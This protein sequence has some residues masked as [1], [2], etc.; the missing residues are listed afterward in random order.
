VIFVDLR[1]R[2]GLVQIVFNPSA[3]IFE[4][5]GELRHEIRGA[6]TG[7]CARTSR[8]NGQCQSGIGRRRDR[9][10]ELELL[11]RSDPLPFQLDENVNEKCGSLPLHRPA[12]R[13]RASAA[14]APS[15]HALDAEFL[16]AQG[17]SIS[18]R[19][20]LTKATPEGARDY[21]VPSRTHSGKFLQ[22]PQS[23]QILQATADDGRHGSLLSVCAAFATGSTA[24]SQPEFTQ[25][26][27]ET[28]FLR[29]DRS[30][31]SWSSWCGPLFVEVLGGSCRRRFRA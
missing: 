24:R 6:R 18:R 26:D 30:C 11:N 4:V 14:A 25:L 7:L 31:S 20:M 28:S 9:G 29:Q 16:D 1:D 21:L 19:R 2:E 17:S 3:G 23:P 13:M 15:H 12:A 8:G 22:L 5:A 27:V 10:A